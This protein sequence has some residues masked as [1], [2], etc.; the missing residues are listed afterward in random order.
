MV[1]HS[2]IW[3]VGAGLFLGIVSSADAAG[4][5]VVMAKQ[6]LTSGYEGALAAL[7][8]TSRLLAVRPTNPNA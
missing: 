2:I 1:A 6:S 8:Q 4:K 7:P 5:P 3:F